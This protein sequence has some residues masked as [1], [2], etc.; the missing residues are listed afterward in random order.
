MDLIHDG[1]ARDGA[2]LQGASDVV[3]RAVAGHG[4]RDEGEGQAGAVLG[5]RAGGQEQLFELLVLGVVVDAGFDDVAVDGVA[6]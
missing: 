3:A 1:L 2:F 6:V 4:G 5:E